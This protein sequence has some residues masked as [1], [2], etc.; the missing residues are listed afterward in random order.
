MRYFNR[1]LGRLIRLKTWQRHYLAWDARTRGRA[2]YNM[3]GPRGQ[4]WATQSRWFTRLDYARRL[5][6]V[7]RRLVR[8]KMVE[9]S[10]G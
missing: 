7:R 4:C 8:V 3:S 2:Q 1:D 5:G 9:V 10:R 6:V